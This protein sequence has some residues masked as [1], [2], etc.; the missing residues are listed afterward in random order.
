MAAR[1]EHNL[2]QLVRQA[3]GDAA[4]AIGFGTDHGTVTAAPHWGAEAQTMEVQPAH[5]R[6]YEHLFHL[7]GEDSFF[8]PLREGQVAPGVREALLEEQLERAIGVIYRPQTELASHY[9]A[10]RLP[11]QFDEYCWFDATTAVVPLAG[12]EHTP[13]DPGHPFAALDI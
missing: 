12:A 11:A 13:L 7:V 9:F 2:G 8:L 10:A 4:Y 5:P 3:Y 6:S 1:G